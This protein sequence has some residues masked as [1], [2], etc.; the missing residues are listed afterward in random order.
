[1]QVFNRGFFFI[2][3]GGGAVVIFRSHLEER[4]A[5]LGLYLKHSLWYI[6]N[7]EYFTVSVTNIR[8]NLCVDINFDSLTLM[9]L[10]S[11]S[12][13][14]ENPLFFQCIISIS[15]GIALNIDY[16]RSLHRYSPFKV[17]VCCI[18]R[19]GGGEINFTLFS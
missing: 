4:I 2:S 11:D 16:L 13:L 15:N 6:L 3:G 17:T 19:T 5:L 12:Y 18:I 8:K 14:P 1:L 9:N 10:V 7:Y